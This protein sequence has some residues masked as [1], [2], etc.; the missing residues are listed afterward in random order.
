MRSC[1]RCST[2]A[3]TETE[4]SSARTAGFVRGPVVPDLECVHGPVQVPQAVLAEIHQEYVGVRN[5]GCCR[6]T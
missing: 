2:K 6:G 3:G 4:G 1:S 5:F